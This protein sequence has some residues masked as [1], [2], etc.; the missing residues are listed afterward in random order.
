MTRISCS[1]L[2]A[3]VLALIPLAYAQ[4]PGPAA[5]SGNARLAALVPAGLSPED[6]CRG[7]KDLG[8][9][10]ATLHIAQNLSIPFADL[11]DRVTSGQSL[12]TVIH[13]FKPDVDSRREAQRAEEQA[14]ADLRSQT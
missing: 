6:A 8:E 3:L 10:S 1:L 14:R 2:T 5:V 13:A 11:K 4:S 9:C 12:G 7:F